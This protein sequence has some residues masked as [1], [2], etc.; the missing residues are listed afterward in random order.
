[1]VLT[2]EKYKK[3]DDHQEYKRYMES[4]GIVVEKH[5]KNESSRF[6]YNYFMTFLFEICMICIMI[7]YYCM[8]GKII[9]NILQ[10][11]LPENAAKIKEMK[12]IEEQNRQKEKEKL[13]HNKEKED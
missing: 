11:N 1:M 5:T 13:D 6:H 9:S 12:K 8:N 4:I 10:C 2:N 7:A 3:E